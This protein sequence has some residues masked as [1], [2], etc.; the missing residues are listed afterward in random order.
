M[1]A[2]NLYTSSHRL[3]TIFKLCMVPNKTQM[4]CK[5]MLHCLGDN[6]KEKACA[7]RMLNSIFNLKLAESADVNSQIWR[8]G[9]IQT[10]QQWKR[11][12]YCYMPQH[13]WI[14]Q[15]QNKQDTRTSCC[16]ALFIFTHKTYLQCCLERE[17][18]S[19]LGWWKYSTHSPNYTHL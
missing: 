7:F 9:C 2:Y 15:T 4:L 3:E 19:P 1:F 14:S 8:A 17:C 5:C 11:I 16:S 18:E 10:T 6:D 12:N 13:G